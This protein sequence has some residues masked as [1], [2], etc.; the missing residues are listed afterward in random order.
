[1]RL[2]AAIDARKPWMWVTVVVAL[3]VACVL[4]AG[5]GTARAAPRISAWATAINVGLLAATFVAI[6]W[7]SLEAQGM[8]REMV[9]Q[10][11]MAMEHARRDQ[12]DRRRRRLA[13]WSAMSAEVGLCAGLARTYTAA[14][15]P[16]SPLWRLS[17]IV[18]YNAFPALLAD[19]VVQGS[20]TASI[21]R[22]YSQVEQINRGL[23][24]V[25]DA[26]N[27]PRFEQEKGRLWDKARNLVDPACPDPGGPYYDPVRTLIE[28]HIRQEGGAP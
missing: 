4:T 13:H 19:G 24:Y 15:T 20:E 18:Y 10:N 23:D 11:E 14:S 26:R 6:L 25:H 22:F 8:R 7:Y 3:G 5:I 16:S 21:V 2:I 27:G 17:T 12:D 9:R 28:R 1:V